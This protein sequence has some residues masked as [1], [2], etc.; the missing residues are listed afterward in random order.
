VEAR[1][2]TQLGLFTLGEARALGLRQQAVSYHARPGGRWRRVLPRV[3]ELTALPP[4]QRRPMFAAQLWAGPGAVLSHR[5]AG[6]ILALDGIRE[7]PPE[8]LS[9]EPKVTNSVVV[10]RGP[11]AMGD[12]MRTGHLRHTTIVRTVLDL[13]CLLDDDTLE[14]VVESALRKNPRWERNFMAAAE[15][16]RRGC[17]ALQR[18]LTRRG[19]GTPP[20]ESE[21]ETR[22]I[23]LLRT[24]DVPT[25]VRQH[26][27]VGDNHQVL[28]RLDLCWPRAKLWVEL[29]GRAWHDRPEALFR[30]RRRQ[31]DVVAEIEWLP[32][33]FTW[34][35]VVDHP[36]ETASQTE[37]VCRRR[38]ALT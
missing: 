28:G 25:P 20:T 12:I 24:V 34:A 14:L 17:R 10:H 1:A 13:S 29:D 9:M 21:L 4:D 37:L 33:R 2:S 30:D 31:N 7:A 35:D 32:L 11:V 15:S 18:V 5:A 8:I 16:G 23:Q 38:M 27:V 3:Y 22:Y 36:R 19:P 6:L 26:R